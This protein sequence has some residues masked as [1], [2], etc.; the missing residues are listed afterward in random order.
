MNSKFQKILVNI[1]HNLEKI[2]KLNKKEMLVDSIRYRLN[3]CLAIYEEELN[4]K[5][6]NLC[7]YISK[8]VNSKVSR[9]VDK[10]L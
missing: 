7:L 4:I 10:I 8:Y 9:K 3:S 6:D 1:L 5:F 2:S